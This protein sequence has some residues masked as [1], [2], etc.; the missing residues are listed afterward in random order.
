MLAQMDSF[1]SEGVS[2]PWMAI[3]AP[4]GGHVDAAPAATNPHGGVRSGPMQ[5]TAGSPAEATGHA[6]TRREVHGNQ[7]EV[8]DH[9]IPLEHG[10]DGQR[11]GLA[12]GLRRA[13]EV[14]HEL[15]AAFVPAQN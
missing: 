2:Y 4:G 14:E 3:G 1:T 6:W 15:A 5:E 7:E 10:G 13:D 8:A 12:R 9:R 11:S